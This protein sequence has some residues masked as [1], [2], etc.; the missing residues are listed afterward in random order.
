MSLK[1]LP[2]A[3]AVHVHV[4][5]D[6]KEHVTL[7]DRMLHDSYPLQTALQTVTTL[8]FLVESVHTTTTFWSSTFPF[9]IPKPTCVSFI[10]Y[11]FPSEHVH[12]IISQDLRSPIII[13]QVYDEGHIFITLS[14]HC[15]PMILGSK[16][17]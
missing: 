7:H 2:S 4:W 15:M 13:I 8:S 14:P 5:S 9:W 6:L 1:E 17:I 16:C 10:I 3:R 11:K 12:N